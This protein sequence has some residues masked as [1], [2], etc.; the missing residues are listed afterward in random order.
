[1]NPVKAVLFDFDGTI[2][3]LRHGWENIMEPLMIELL[4][5]ESREKIKTYIDESTGIQTIFQMKWLAEQ[6]QQ[7]KGT[8]L[9]PWEY[10]AEYNRRLMEMVQDRRTALTNGTASREDYMMAGSEDLLQALTAMG[11]KVYVASG[12]DDPDVKAEVEALGLSKYFEKV[13]GA[14]LGKENCSKEQVIRDL[15]NDGIPGNEM[16]VVGDGKVEIMVGREGG[17]RT[18]GLA[19]N[20]AARQ[21]M[22]PIKRQRLEKAGADLILGDFLDK[23]RLMQFF[24]G[25]DK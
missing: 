1:M 19:S 8:A 13:A 18:L 5:E 22:D 16:A 12:T 20:E 11:A 6:V 2:S 15:L 23:D 17:A 7:R 25:E 10:K 4:G 9:D 21:G 14:P 24:T 3:T